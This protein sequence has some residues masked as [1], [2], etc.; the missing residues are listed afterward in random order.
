[1]HAQRE[2]MRAAD[3]AGR[4]EAERLAMQAERDRLAQDLEDPANADVDADRP[5]IGADSVSLLNRR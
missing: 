3:L 2:S 4:K 1:M 5:A